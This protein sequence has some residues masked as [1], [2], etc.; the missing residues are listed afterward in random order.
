MSEDIQKCFKCQEACVR[1]LA[2][3]LE[4]NEDPEFITSL[5]LCALGCQMAAQAMILR[6]HFFPKACLFSAELCESV[7]EQCE[8]FDESEIQDCGRSCR[9]WVRAGRSLAKNSNFHRELQINSHSL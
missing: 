4:M 9:D 2:L 1:A 7:A 8:S 6:S 3:G 5:Q